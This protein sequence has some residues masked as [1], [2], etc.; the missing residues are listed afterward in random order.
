MKKGDKV[1]IKNNPIQD[2]AKNIPGTVTVCLRGIGSQ[3]CD[4]LY[5]RYKD[6]KGVSRVCPFDEVDLE[7]VSNR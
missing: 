5:V 3:G 7:L 6:H 2:K 1:T 4:L